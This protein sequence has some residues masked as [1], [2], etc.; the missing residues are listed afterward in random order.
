[1]F[2]RENPYREGAADSTLLLPELDVILVGLG[3]YG[4]NLCEF[5]RH[6][7]M[8]IP[9]VNFDPAATECRRGRG[10]SVLTV[11]LLIS[12]HIKQARASPSVMLRVPEVVDDRLSRGTQ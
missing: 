1:M 11:I 2:E 3:K 5:L 9:G 8:K 6:R 4:S 10:L 7:S 12:R